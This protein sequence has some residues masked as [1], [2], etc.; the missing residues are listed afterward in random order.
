[1][2]KPINRL[3]ICFAFLI[4]FC[5]MFIRGQSNVKAE[6]TPTGL[7]SLIIRKYS[8]GDYS[9]LLPGA[10]L[11][12]KQ[13][14]GSGFQEKTFYSNNSGEKVDLPN[15]IYILSEIKPPQGYGVATP[16]TFKIE[17]GKVLIK[18]DEQF[19]ENPYKEVDKPYSVEAYNDYLEYDVLSTQNYAKFY[20]AKNGDG[21]KQVVYC[22]NADL[23]SPPDSYDNG[24]SIEPDV[25][26]MS[27][28]KFTQVKGVDLLKYAVS[29]R[30]DNAQ[31][32]LTYIKKVIHKGYKGENS[33]IPDGLTAT[34]FR[35]ATQLAIYYFTNSADL[36]TLKTYN[37]N[38][39]YHGF[40]DMNEATVQA[41]R[42]LIDYAMNGE[43]AAALPDL[44]FFIP[45]NNAYQSLIGTQY[46]PEA[47][48]DILRMEDSLAPI[49][50][51]THKLNLSKKVSGTA[52]DKTKEFDFNIEL[53]DLAGNALQGTYPTSKNGVTIVDGKAHFTLKDSETIEILN[54]PTGYSYT[55]T[56]VNSD[57]YKTTVT[58]DSEAP[59][60]TKQT[61]KEGIS[62]DTVLTFENNK[63]AVVPTGI[64]SQSYSDFLLIIAPVLLF[65]LIY[66]K[67]SKGDY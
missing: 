5:L 66:Y 16:I 46:H 41:T 26:T 32:L 34:Q 4:L 25:T 9:K 23:H 1:M 13:I 53:K 31:Q 6:T 29:P 63:E 44:D 67:F 19:V 38:K 8:E 21:S 7:T 22:F 57:D 24:D 45:N 18:K 35:A 56:E 3:S 20:Y 40:E 14:E 2:K 42:N 52:S 55:I 50:P 17:N 60:E 43:S 48:V 65:G 39:G 12:L 58:I 15:G 30:T 62:S 54:L 59:V 64:N 49:V 61:I 51:V 10:T 27:E 11:N 36:D 37:D 33:N 28:V 47:L